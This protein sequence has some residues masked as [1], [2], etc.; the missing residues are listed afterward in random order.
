LGRVAV[1]VFCTLRSENT[2]K[3]NGMKTV[4]TEIKWALV[5]VIMSLLWIL[6]ERLAGLHDQ[7]I[8]KHSVFTNFIAIPAIAVYVF[9]MLE[10]RRRF[11]HGSLS[12]WQ[13]FKSGLILTLIITIFSP[14]TKIIATMVITPLYF[15]NVIRHS[16]ASNIMTQAEAENYFSIKSF[17]INGLIETPLMGVLT[18]A[19]V[20]LFVKRKPTML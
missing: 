15:E 18:A 2:H 13:G 9:E 20:A 7:H 17:I 11:Y 8:D 5:F 19:V 6:M 4:V 12:Y 10:K 1:I 14:V 16:V 3:E